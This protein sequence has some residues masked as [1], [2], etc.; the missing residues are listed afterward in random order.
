M[1]I[2][3]LF[4]GATLAVRDY[5]CEAGPADR[6]VVE[7]FNEHSISYVREGSFGCS[8]RGHAHELV[9]GAFLIG[10]PGDEYVCTHDHRAGGDTCLSFHYDASL[11]DAIGATR[12]G[13]RAGAVP[14]A[15]ELIVLG[16]LAQA[17]AR[18]DSDLGLDEVGVLLARRFLALRESGPRRSPALSSRDRRR[19]VATALWL[20][21]HAH[22]AIDLD[23]AAREA[24]LSPYHFL[25]V[26]GAVLGVTPHQYL[27]RARLRRAARLLVDADRPITEVALDAGFGD[28]SNFVRTFGRAAGVSPR[29]FRRAARGDRKILQERLVAGA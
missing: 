7:C 24:A 12:R 11:V 5:R 27:V 23:A 6:P 3:S 26:F 18:G 22:E 2:V 28:I 25:R 13:W 20:D 1:R 8:A 4:E 21:A 16:E 10:H 17:V 9:A 15:A 19:A 29:A 14:P